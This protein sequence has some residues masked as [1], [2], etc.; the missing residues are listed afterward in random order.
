MQLNSTQQILFDTLE[1]KYLYDIPT[2]Y[3][4]KQDEIIE[5]VDCHQKCNA[6][7]IAKIDGDTYCKSCIQRL[8]DRKEVNEED[9]EWQN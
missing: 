6:D 3:Q 9:I 5:C 4:E 8:I 2:Y 1:Q 7:D